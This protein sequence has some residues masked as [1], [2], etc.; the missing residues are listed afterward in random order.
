MNEGWELIESD[1]NPFNHPRPQIVI[2]YSV[3][4]YESV[5]LSLF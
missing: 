4:S 2:T 1:E 5:S 3:F